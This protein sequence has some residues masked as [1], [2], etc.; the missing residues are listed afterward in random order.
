M[1]QI[2]KLRVINDGMLKFTWLNNCRLAVAGDTHEQYTQIKDL[3]FAVYRWN[4]KR[5]GIWSRDMSPVLHT[6]A[7]PVSCLN[8]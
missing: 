4:E 3:A 2:L 1:K 7:S 5:A 6:L 8:Y